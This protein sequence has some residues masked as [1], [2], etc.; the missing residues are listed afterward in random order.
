MPVTN[1]LPSGAGAE[2]RVVKT[3]GERVD[4]PA[5]PPAIIIAVAHQRAPPAALPA[6]HSSVPT[7][8]G[9]GWGQQGLPKP[10]RP[11]AFGR[12]AYL[13]AQGE[14]SP[15]PSWEKSAAPLGRASGGNGQ[16]G[17]DRTTTA[18]EP[19]RPPR[20]TSEQ[21]GRGAARTHLRGSRRRS[22][23]CWSAPHASHHPAS[24]RRVYR[25]VYHSGWWWSGASRAASCESSASIGPHHPR[26]RRRVGSRIH[27]LARRRACPQTAWRCSQ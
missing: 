4:S 1:A 19:L 14:G 7:A 11:S 12:A 2:P 16:A 24:G 25:R 5:P 18:R 13:A 15:A 26:R 10:S 21:L 3:H 23:R 20:L 27:R 9:G 22:R 6:S 17:I 8:G